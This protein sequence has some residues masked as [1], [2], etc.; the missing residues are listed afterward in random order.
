MITNFLSMQTLG[1]GVF[2]RNE[3]NLTLFK[4]LNEEDL[5]S[6]GISSFG[7]RRIMLTAI[8]GLFFFHCNE[9]I[10]RFRV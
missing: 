1:A 5:I 4:T 2:L 3:V 8:K 9:Y 7:A 10:Q 6:L